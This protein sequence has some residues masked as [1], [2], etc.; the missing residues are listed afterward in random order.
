MNYI[1]Y[2]DPGHGWLRV[3]KQEIE[4]IKWL[5][6]PCSY[7]DEFF[8]YLEE[9]SDMSIFIKAKGITNFKEWW[10]AHVQVQYSGLPRSKP[11]YKPSED[12]CYQYPNPVYF[13]ET[14]LD[15]ATRNV[16]IWEEIV[17]KF[18]LMF[19]FIVFNEDWPESRYPFFVKQHI[20][21]VE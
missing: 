1:F 14:T 12:D 4:D 18:C 20:S 11:Y 9:D 21:Q 3:P 2:H 5:I 6:S 19:N 13:E 10:E 15:L 8:V 16:H 17:D 7:M